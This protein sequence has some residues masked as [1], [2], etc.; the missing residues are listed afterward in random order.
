MNLD[1]SSTATG[2]QQILDET[3]FLLEGFY[4]SSSNRSRLDV[5]LGAYFQDDA[6]GNEFRSQCCFGRP[7]EAVSLDDFNQLCILPITQWRIRLA[8]NGSLDTVVSPSILEAAERE[9]F[10]ANFAATAAGNIVA[11]LKDIVKEHPEGKT[12]ISHIPRIGGIPLSWSTQIIGVKNLT[13]PY[14]LPPL[15]ILR[16]RIVRSLELG[17]ERKLV[18][19]SF[20][21]FCAESGSLWHVIDYTLD[22]NSIY[23]QACSRFPK[24][25]EELLLRKKTTL[26][27][28]AGVSPA[29]RYPDVEAIVQDGFSRAAQRR[30]E[31]KDLHLDDGSLGGTVFALHNGYLSAEWVAAYLV[32]TDNNLFMDD[33]RAS[34]LNSKERKLRIFS[35][36]HTFDQ[37]TWLQFGEKRNVY[38]YLSQKASAAEEGWLS[39]SSYVINLLINFIN[40]RLNSE[41]EARYNLQPVEYDAGVVN[42]AN[43]SMGSYGLHHDAKF[44]LVDPSIP[45]YSSFSLMVPTLAIQNHSAPSSHISWF[46]KGDLKKTK[47]AS[48]T[49][50]FVMTHW[51]LMGVNA[52]FEHEVRSTRLSTHYYVSS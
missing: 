37:P 48:F 29:S 6:K 50:D 18:Q 36:A 20:K 52:E 2:C 32:D 41:T 42:L 11:V 46:L 14:I 10:T 5:L 35:I 45:S 23:L 16:E 3:A 7:G 12:I 4:E 9:H 31:S 47:L 51:Q 34:S 49:Q 8:T 30:M 24:Y 15:T 1:K 19:P 13:P 40:D 22:I 21:L 26:D 25:L 27:K 39:I 28:L 17:L 38:L 43:P 44:G 33:A